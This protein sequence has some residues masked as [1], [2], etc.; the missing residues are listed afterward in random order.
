MRRLPTKV[1]YTR[2][3][4]PVNVRAIRA[5]YGSGVTTF[6]AEVWP[7][8]DLAGHLPPPDF[9][10]IDIEG[11]EVDALKGAT[12]TLRENRPAVFVELHGA[13]AEDKAARADSVITDLL[14]HGYRITQVES[15]TVIDR[16]NPV[17]DGSGN[18]YAVPR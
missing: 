5:A 11:M 12:R 6:N 2:P 9:L 18:L 1:W 16:T 13:T 7:I 15:G 3:T 14:L 8:D 17:W 10:K 4:H